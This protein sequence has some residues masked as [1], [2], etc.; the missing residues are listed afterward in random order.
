MDEAI[1]MPDILHVKL[2][3]RLDNTFDIHLQHPGVTHYNFYRA[4]FDILF[5]PGFK[6]VEMGKFHFMPETSEGVMLL[7]QLFKDAILLALI[8]SHGLDTQDVPTRRLFVG[9]AVAGI[10][11]AQWLALEMFNT[12]YSDVA[13]QRELLKHVM[14]YC[15][16]GGINAVTSKE[17]GDCL[18]GVFLEVFM[19]GKIGQQKKMLTELFEDHEQLAR[20]TL[21]FITIF[22][23]FINDPQYSLKGIERS[24]TTAVDSERFPSVA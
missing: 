23:S 6:G 5:L 12:C 20:M 1:E 11:E 13:K 22:A 21:A 4:V 8:R 9:L 24:G 16:S 18:D 10:R 14:E 15:S 3:D 19:A 7:S 2:A 17:A